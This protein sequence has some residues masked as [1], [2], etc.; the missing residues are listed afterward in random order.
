[1]RDMVGSGAS[2]GISGMV[3]YARERIQK[4]EPWT[5]QGLLGSAA[6]GA[7]TGV[8]S[9]GLSPAAGQVSKKLFQVGLSVGINTGAGF[10][11]EMVKSGVNGETFDPAKALLSSGVA[12]TGSSAWS[13]SRGIAP[14]GYGG[15]FGPCT[16]SPVEYFSKANVTSEAVNG[17]IGT[18]TNALL[19]EV[20]ST[21]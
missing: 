19:D 15:L 16:S 21:K 11:G 8:L 12:A 10:A 18:G 6:G 14:E 9:G 13:S 7:A 5:A 1:M 17:L 2:G 4:G 20:G 3:D